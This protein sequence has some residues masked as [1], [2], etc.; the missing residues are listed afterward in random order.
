MGSAGAS[1]VMLQPAGEGTGVVAGGTTRIVLEM[2]G[3]SNIT[4]KQLKTNNPLNNARATINGLK[5]LRSL[6]VLAKERNIS[7]CQLLGNDFMA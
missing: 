6:P 4:G 3:I 1:L 5:D 7:L 2:A